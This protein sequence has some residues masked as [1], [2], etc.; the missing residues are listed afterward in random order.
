MPKAIKDR[1]PMETF[2]IP[3]ARQSVVEVAKANPNIYFLFM[4]TNKVADLPNII[5]LDGNQDLNY[6][7]KFINTCD[8]ML[9][10]RKVGETFGLAVAEFSL[11][12]KPVITYGGPMRESAHLQMLG[13]KAIRFK[14]KPEL[15][16]ILTE[17]KPVEGDYN[18]YKDYNPKAIMEIFN[19]IFLK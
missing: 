2:D 8:A 16:K 9:H 6:K 18:A 17:F 7:V 5:H 4:F 10:A 15:V 11:R 12:N 14:T 3:M 19:N 1:L 13:D